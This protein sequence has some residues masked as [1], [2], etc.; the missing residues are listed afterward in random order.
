M[1]KQLFGSS[2]FYGD[3][4][5]HCL[6]YNKNM[7]SLSYV[8]EVMLGKHSALA[9]FYPYFGNSNFSSQNLRFLS[10]YCILYFDN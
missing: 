3:Q 10:K 1:D 9:I 8:S 7:L 5:K 2:A 4:Y 6:V